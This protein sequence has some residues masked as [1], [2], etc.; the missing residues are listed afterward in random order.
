MYVGESLDEVNSA[1]IRRT[2]NQG[3]TPGTQNG[4][5]IPEGTKRVMIA[6]PAT[7]AANLTSVIDVDGMG[8]DVFGS[9]FTESTVDV[10]GLD[11]Y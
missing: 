10:E 8:L 4:V 1:F 3:S 9:N 7:N 11:G 2:S 6:I 5:T